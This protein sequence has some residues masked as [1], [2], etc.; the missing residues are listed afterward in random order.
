MLSAGVRSARCA[1]SPVRL[2]FLVHGI[3]SIIILATVRMTCGICGFWLLANQSPTISGPSLL[4]RV[5]SQL[6]MDILWDTIGYYGHAIGGV[7]VT[8][9][10]CYY[11]LLCYYVTMCAG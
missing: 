6:V 4:C 9:I 10:K 8:M 7:I 1:C 11:G 3:I 5:L 2:F